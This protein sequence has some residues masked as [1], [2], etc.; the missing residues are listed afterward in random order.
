MHANS[1]KGV[2]GGSQTR[3]DYTQPG[4]TTAKNDLC[5]ELKQL[6]IDGK[7]EECVCRCEKAHHPA[8]LVPP[9]EH[10]LLEKTSTQVTVEFTMGGAEA[11]RKNERGMTQMVSYPTEQLFDT[12]GAREVIEGKRR[13]CRICRH[14]LKWGGCAEWSNCSYV[15]VMETPETMVLGPKGERMPPTPMAFN[16][17]KSKLCDKWKQAIKERNVQNLVC[18][19]PKAH[20][21]DELVPP[22]GRHALHE[23]GA[24]VDV[25]DLGESGIVK[26]YP[27]HQI[28]ITAGS[29]RYLT[30]VYSMGR[31]PPRVTHCYN[32][33]KYGKCD[34]WDECR[35][36]HVQ[37]PRFESVAADDGFFQPAPYGG[38]PANFPPHAGGAPPLRPG[39]WNCPA[40][41]THNFAKRSSCFSCGAPGGGGGPES[42]FPPAHAP[43]MG[44]PRGGGF[45]RG[46]AGPGA[47]GPLA[48]PAPNHL[49]QRKREY[50]KA[51]LCTTTKAG[52]EP[53]T[54]TCP[55]A[56]SF[57]EL[58][59]PPSHVRLIPGYEIGVE[60]SDKS[61]K[62]S[63]PSD[64]VYATSGAVRVLEQLMRGNSR[65][66]PVGIHCTVFVEQGKCNYW[67]DCHYIHVSSTRATPEEIE[68]AHEA[69]NTRAATAPPAGPPM[70]PTRPPFGGGA[71]GRF[72]P[73]GGGID[74]LILTGGFP[75]GGF[76]GGAG[77]FPQ[78]GGG[79]PPRGGGMGGGFP[80][81]GGGGGGFAPRGGG[82]GVFPMGGGGFTPRG[83]SSAPA[84]PPPRTVLCAQFKASGQASG[85]TCPHAH[86]Y[87]QLEPSERHQLL[88]PGKFIT[89]SDPV[90]GSTQYPSQQI[91]QTQGATQVVTGKI[92][93][94]SHC[95]DFLKHGKCEQ[96]EK[97]P[98]IHVWRPPQ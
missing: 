27:T 54:C 85:C 89:V 42:F 67:E 15:H 4:E 80:A 30:E 19:C 53:S 46:P 68:A 64:Q 3:F 56:H 6:L 72:V 29:H 28:Y 50:P 40:C 21:L 52:T 39:D 10:V 83:P 23:P 48:G 92:P 91:Y 17:T 25:W 79:F 20:S 97:C 36:V 2:A 8:E 58:V 44:P 22:P 59:E 32:F 31:P 5:P 33:L 14:F 57:E 55:N 45:P 71:A 96:W 78:R 90:Y 69:F 95:R 49:L 12:K 82:G 16:T 70:P 60:T 41:G 47:R 62:A 38:G 75:R 24:F 26:T 51:V 11:A 77:G 1:F 63:Y 87:D 73:R 86:S 61:D 37:N 93:S 7:P 43:P 65:T 81:R 74:P 34:L 66:P 98:N 9:P 18:D 94:G 84:G 13:A 35:N 88:S 76:R